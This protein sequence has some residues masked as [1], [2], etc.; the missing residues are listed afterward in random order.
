MPAGAVLATGYS[1]ECDPHDHAEE[2]ALA[3]VAGQ[4]AARCDQSIPRWNPACAACPAPGRAVKLIV[5][6]GITRVVLALAGAARF[7]ARWR[8]RLAGG[9]WRA[10]DRGPGTRA[11]ARAVKAAP[12]AGYGGPA[13][14]TKRAA[15][16]RP[17]PPG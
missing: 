5:A 11:D 3:T 17:V 14:G 1:R 16:A 9:S 7:R 15:P 10:G 13:T 2:G 12:A 4:P 8:V 6:A